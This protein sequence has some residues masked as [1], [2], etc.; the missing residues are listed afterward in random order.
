MDHKIV[1]TDGSYMEI[2]ISN[3]EEFYKN[4]NLSKRKN[5]FFCYENPN[6]TKIFFNTDHVVT[7]QSG[8]KDAEKKSEDQKD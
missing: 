7:I 3:S 5:L 2:N 1:F 4:L 6:G 8:F